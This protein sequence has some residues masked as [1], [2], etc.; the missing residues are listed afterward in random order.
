MELLRSA[1][2]RYWVALW[3]ACY[4]AACVHY[5]EPEPVNPSDWADPCGELPPVYGTDC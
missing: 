5:P 2:P 4:L 3:L 1:R